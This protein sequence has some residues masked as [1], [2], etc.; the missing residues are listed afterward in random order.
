MLAS[1]CRILR[2][3][4]TYKW[5]LNAIYKKYKDDKIAKEILS[6]DHHECPFYDA[7]DSW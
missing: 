3:S 1:I 6:N 2:I 7:L 4:I 5:K